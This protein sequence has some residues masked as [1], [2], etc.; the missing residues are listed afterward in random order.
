MKTTSFQGSDKMCSQNCKIPWFIRGV[1]PFKI[2]FD[3]RI[4]ISK[5]TILLLNY[6]HNCYQLTIEFWIRKIIGGTHTTMNKQWNIANTR[7][8]TPIPRPSYATAVL[9]SNLYTNK[10]E[11]LEIMDSRIKNCNNPNFYLKQSESN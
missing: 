10:A 11:R 8:T 1:K 2:C 3:K 7:S 5:I 4:N 9:S 6:P